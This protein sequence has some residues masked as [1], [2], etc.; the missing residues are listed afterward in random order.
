[1]SKEEDRELAGYHPIPRKLFWACTQNLCHS[2]QFGT[3]FLA[4]L[5]FHARKYLPP[6]ANFPRLSFDFAIFLATGFAYALLAGL[7]SVLDAGKC[8]WSVDTCF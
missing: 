2:F 7:L 5:V 3:R 4:P 1:M 8:G 6:D